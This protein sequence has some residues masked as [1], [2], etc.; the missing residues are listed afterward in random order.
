MSQMHR[1]E[2]A[3]IFFTILTLSPLV[4][5]ADKPKADEPKEAFCETVANRP[6]KQSSKSKISKNCTL[7]PFDRAANTIEGGD[8]LTSPINEKRLESIWAINSAASKTLFSGTIISYHYGTAA[9]CRRFDFKLTVLS[10]E[11]SNV[12][13][14]GPADIAEFCQYNEKAPFE[15]GVLFVVPVKVLWAN[16]VSFE[17]DKSDPLRKEPGPISAPTY[18]C[19]EKPIK[20]V[21]S[22]PLPQPTGEGIRPCTSSSRIGGFYNPT[23]GKF[24]NR[25]TQT[26]S[27]QGTLSFTPAIGNVP[28]GQESCQQPSPPPGCIKTPTENL[29]FDVQLYPSGVL[30]VGWLGFPIAFEKANTATANLNSLS[31]AIS[32]DI[33]LARKHPYFVKW[34]SS[35]SLRALIRPPDFR[36]QYGVEMAS[37]FLHD[38]NFVGAASVRIPIVFDLRRQPSAITIFPAFGV[39]GGSHFQTHPTITGGAVTDDILRKVVGFDSSL[40][41]PFIITHA[42]L[43]DK[44]VTVDFSWRT[45]YL[46]YREPFTDYVSGNFETLTKQQRSYWRGSYVVP[47]ST[48]VS[49]KVTI[50]HGGLPPDFA[51]LGYSMNI[52]LTF[53]NPGYSEH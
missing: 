41:F 23:V 49:F 9:D 11:S 1:R 6:A 38:A 25:L 24:Y 32:Y 26:G 10:E 20:K 42:L 18:Y 33:P 13:I 45:R 35:P 52:G 22:D 44:P 19:G 37:S 43:G 34:G 2:P 47:V 51:Y 4:Q 8:V 48:L 3:L 27:S 36:V 16:I 5:A 39:E 50:Q 31:V 21:A 7:T 29:N 40:R 15:N 53:G 28:K 46:S 12:L 14:Y 17:M 30:G